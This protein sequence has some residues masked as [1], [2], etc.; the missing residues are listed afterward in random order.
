MNVWIAR[1]S[2]ATL[3]QIEHHDRSIVIAKRRWT[4]ITWAVCLTR[5]GCNV[6]IWSGLLAGWES[7]WTFHGERF[8]KE[9][10]AAPLLCILAFWCTSVLVFSF[11]ILR[12]YHEVV[13]NGSAF[14]YLATDDYECGYNSGNNNNNIDC[15]KIN[16]QSLSFSISRYRQLR[17]LL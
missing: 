14:Y 13:L 17:L 15:D 1:A 16:S 5:L 11:Y 3:S 12:H 9:V 2:R 4:I 7:S 6:W 10:A 8:Y